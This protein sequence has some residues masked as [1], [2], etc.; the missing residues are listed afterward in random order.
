MANVH[1]DPYRLEEFA[2][3]LVT[4]AREVAAVRQFLSASLKHLSATWRD[5][6]YERFVSNFLQTERLLDQLIREIEQVH[7]KLRED[8]RYIRDYFSQP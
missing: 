6:E 4:F 5:Q 8:A 3:R 2:S 7:P 1:V